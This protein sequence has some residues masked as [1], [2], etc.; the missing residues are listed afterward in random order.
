MIR[1]LVNACASGEQLHLLRNLFADVAL[2]QESHDMLIHTAQVL[3]DYFKFS[4]LNQG[5]VRDWV[6]FFEN[7]LPGMLVAGQLEE[8][9]QLQDGLVREAAQEV[10]LLEVLNDGLLLLLVEALQ[11]PLVIIFGDRQEET[12]FGGQN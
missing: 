1:L 7:V 3:L 5:D 11:I 8:V 9:G 10:L 12:A 6:S 4:V 2:S